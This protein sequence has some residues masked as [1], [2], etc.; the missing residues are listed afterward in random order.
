M[1]PEYGSG[2]SREQIV[3]NRLRPLNPLAGKESGAP[4][5]FVA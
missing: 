2:E 3:H 5:W 4:S 1:P